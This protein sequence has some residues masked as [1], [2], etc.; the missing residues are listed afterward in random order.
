NSSIVSLTRTT[1]QV[2]SNVIHDMSMLGN[3]SNWKESQTE[4]TDLT[5]NIQNK[6]A[7]I[8]VAIQE[9]TVYAL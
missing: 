2:I 5:M 1:K 6:S 9:Y 3:L 8:F 4:L 7:P